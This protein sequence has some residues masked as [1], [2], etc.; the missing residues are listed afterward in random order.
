MIFYDCVCVWAPKDAQ[1]PRLLRVS[2]REV[3]YKCQKINRSRTRSLELYGI[4]QPHFSFMHIHFPY[5]DSPI[6]DHSQKRP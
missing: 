6:I 2:S 1:V 5:H 3:V 4:F